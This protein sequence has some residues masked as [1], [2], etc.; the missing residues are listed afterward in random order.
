MIAK[1]QRVLFVCIGNSCRSQ[2]AEWFARTYGSD[3]M[4]ASSAGM[5]PALGVAEMT[6]QVMVDKNIVMR[7]PFP[8][9]IIEFHPDNVDIV[10]NMSG[11]GL[12]KAFRSKDVRVWTVADPIG[13]KQSFYE[14]VRDQ[15]EGLVMRLV[16]ELRNAGGGLQA[17]RR[18]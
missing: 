8:K 12:P 17:G 11:S 15:I 13:K 10:V 3:V 9:G 6:K 14:E 7:D 1:K 16:L 18:R 5:A 2:M 4:E